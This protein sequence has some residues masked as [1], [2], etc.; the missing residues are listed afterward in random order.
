[1]LRSLGLYLSMSPSHHLPQSGRILV[2]HRGEYAHI[3]RSHRECA[4]RMHECCHHR[5]QYIPS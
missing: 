3:S 5:Y 4:P 2:K 1:M